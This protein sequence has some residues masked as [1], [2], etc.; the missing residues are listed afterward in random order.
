MIARLNRAVNEVLNEEKTAAA[1]QEHDGGGGT[2]QSSSTHHPAAPRGGIGTV[3]LTPADAAGFNENS[4]SAL[5]AIDNNPR[6]F[7]ATSWYLGN[8]VFGGLKQGSGLILDMGGTVRLS[9]VTVTFGPTPGLNVDIK[10]GNSNAQDPGS[11]A[12][13]QATADAMPTVASKSDVS[14]LE[15]FTINSNATGRYV[16]IWFTKLPRWIGHP[17]KYQAQIYNIVVKGSH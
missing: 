11:D 2:P 15:T 9:S 13:G 6:T 8:P 7:W 14:G 17:N 12:V 4:D 3:V 10:I 1:R 16:L 5:A